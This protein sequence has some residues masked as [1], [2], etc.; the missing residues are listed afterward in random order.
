MALNSEQTDI[1][2]K[3]R[4]EPGIVK[5]V[6]NDWKKN[7][8]FMLAVVQK[9]GLALE[10]ASEALKADREVVLA[11]VQQNGLALEHASEALR[12]NEEVVLAAV[13]QNRLAINLASKNEKAVLAVVQQDYT[14]LQ[15]AGAD[16][17]G[18]IMLAVV[19][20]NG[21]ALEYASEALRANKKVVLAAVQQNGLAL[22]H[23]S[24]ALRANEE[25][26]LA[27]LQ[28]TSQAMPFVS[29]ELQAKNQRIIT[30]HR[31][32]LIKEHTLTPKRVTQ[33]GTQWEELCRKYSLSEAEKI[34]G[35]ANIMIH[36]HPLDGNRKLEAKIIVKRIE[37]PKREKTPIE[38][39]KEKLTDIEKWIKYCS[40]K[41]EYNQQVVS[42]V[43][44][45]RDQLKGGLTRD[46]GVKKDREV[47]LAAV[48]KS[49]LVLQYASKAL[50]AD[51]EVVLAAVKKNGFALQYASKALKADRDVVLAAVKKNGFALQ[52]ASKALR[53]N[54]EVVLAAV[55]QNEL[56]KKFASKRLKRDLD[57]KVAANVTTSTSSS[58]AP[59][60]ANSKNP[61][62][63]ARKVQTGMKRAKTKHNAPDPASNAPN[64]SARL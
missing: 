54:E 27:A 61:G 23:A 44:L 36:Q 64:N 4:I 28:Q 8:E 60:P 39:S 5:F 24:E 34:T 12:A 3:V 11:A 45:I 16:L 26:V 18:N 25:V 33:W 41:S 31:Q 29:E 17:K 48:N 14:A 50:K 9:N 42:E 2:S 56:A 30:T 62:N 1:I 55:G 15:H 53:A 63:A 7:T 13:R 59:R 51:R 22:E 43:K 57:V 52:Y 37:P 47:V 10:H 58:C 6:E 49:G 32:Q 40:D 38:W 35:F 20:Q 19:Q 21:L 46:P